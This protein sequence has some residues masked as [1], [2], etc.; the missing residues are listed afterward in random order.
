MTSDPAASKVEGTSTSP[1]TLETVVDRYLD[2]LARG[3][4]PDPQVYLDA[5]PELADALHGVF[6]TIDF[7]EATSRS[8][9]ASELRCDQRL[10]DFRILREIGRG[11][12]GVVYEA[13]Q[14]SLDRRVALK[15]LPAGAALA[16]NAVERFGRE[17]AI[18]ARLN[19]PHIVP[20]HAVG[21]EQGIRYYV[22]QFIE[23]RSFAG[24]LKALGRDGAPTA[25][26]EW[27]SRVARWGFQV[28]S[29]LEYAH[30]MGTI[31]R[32]VKP[33]NLLLDANDDVWLTD[34]GLARSTAL[35]SLTISGDVVGTA[36]YMSPEQ[37]RGGHDMVDGRTDLWSLGATLYELLAQVPAF[38][39]E[40]RDQVLARIATGGPVPLR[41]V[42]PAVPRDLATVV[43]TC[44]QR[45]RERR[46]ARARD[47]ADDLRRFLDGHPIVARRPSVLVEAGRFL[48][49][50]RL[51]VAVTLIT[52][53][54]A[55]TSFALVLRLRS[56]QG[57][58]LVADALDQILVEFDGG[59]AQRLLDDA[60]SL[61]VDS[62][63]SHLYRA[64]IPLLSGRPAEAIPSL[65]QA[66]DRD[67]DHVEA[68]YALAYA[69]LATADREAGQLR[70]ARAQDREIGSALGW[71]L[72]GYALAQIEAGE[73]VIASYDRAI[74][75]RRDFAPAIEARAQYR[76]VHL[77]V[78]GDATA[79][80]PLLA[81]CDA[82]TVFRPTSARAFAVQACGHWVGAAF[83][84][85][86]GDHD[87]E[88][89]HLDVCR[90]N[91]ARALTLRVAGDSGVLARYGAF[92]RDTGDFR[93]SADA[94]ARAILAED[95]K[96]VTEQPAFR[97]QRALS[98]QAL[99]ELGDALTE[100][101]R[102]CPTPPGP[103]PLGLQ[104]AV[105][106]AE[107][108]RLEEARAAARDACAVG[109]R[110]QET[111]SIDVAILELLGGEPD[112]SAPASGLK[113]TPSEARPDDDKAAAT[114]ALIGYLAGSC[115]EQEA[116][117]AARTPGSRCATTFAV[118]CRALGRGDREAGRS[119]L[120]D[121]L[122]TGVVLYLQHNL[123]R[124]FRARIDA[125]PRWPSWAPGPR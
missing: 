70:L 58:G 113:A 4:K 43:E 53:V 16:G 1:V 66:L 18:A 61:G 33:S 15:V 13:I 119:A 67:Q 111:V 122:S 59:R 103:F 51:H 9:N 38:D 36:R 78:D 82:L 72:R 79:L 25:D 22:M 19:H 2:E 17:A 52:L 50:H 114:R 5:H 105:L 40:S 75:M 62:A 28:A 104:R 37:A 117:A 89:R 56:I 48:G 35:V 106:L 102:A 39:G 80:A 68:G 115:T 77:L 47:L 11:G 87:A 116:L 99:G 85:T 30:G 109:P 110:D 124:V 42:N 12:M 90:A 120:D 76:T 98:L 26:R 8:L 65:E 97:H 46:Y 125:D 93:G 74:A 55:A 86:Q 108:G 100:I 44:M 107:T 84:A 92:L 63:E 21:E 118:A 96:S 123:A 41:R 71:L 73:E 45:E 121:C 34:F 95:A 88:R 3:L 10:G 91:F 20:V 60:R 64:L 23:G 54:L 101:D 81:D 69:L 6:R 14:C 29:A 83:A 27:F 94:L 31:H 7:I 49:R 112:T 57:E 32:D 24:H